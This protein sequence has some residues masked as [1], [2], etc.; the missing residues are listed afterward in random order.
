MIVH[1]SALV[2]IL[3]DELGSASI[4]EKMYRAEVVLVGAPTALETAMVLSGRLK[5]DARHLVTGLFRS[6]N[7]EIVDFREIHYETAMSAFLR[8]GKGRHQA[9][10]N[11]GDCM[12]YALAKVS[13]MPLL[14]V[15]E[16]FSH[17]DIV[18]A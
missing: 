9:A 13:N 17:T 3:L 5:Q 12:S 15:G 10:L 2:A 1:S 8:Y 14:Y 11:L 16:D 7:F 18:S 4:S 6:L